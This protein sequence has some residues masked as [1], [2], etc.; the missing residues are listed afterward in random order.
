M[1]ARIQRPAP[2]GRDAGTYRV[3][4][5]ALG[6]TSRGWIVRSAGSGNAID[7]ILEFFAANRDGNEPSPIHGPSHLHD[8]TVKGGPHDGEHLDLTGGWMDAGDMIHFAQT[9]SFAAAALEA[10]ARLDPVGRPSSTPRRTSG[11]G[12]W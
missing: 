3:R 8:A 6:Q 9:T 2:F 1:G 5:P 11:S 4:V 12:G 10:A 7:R